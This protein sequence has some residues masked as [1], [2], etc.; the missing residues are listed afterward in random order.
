MTTQVKGT[1]CTSSVVQF[2]IYFTTVYY[3]LLFIA[4]S[5]LSAEVITNLYT[6]CCCTVSLVFN[7]LMEF[8]TLR[9]DFL[10]INL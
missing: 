4:S 3:I 1:R 7:V 10:E 9:K 6:Q 8:Q 2:T 5:W